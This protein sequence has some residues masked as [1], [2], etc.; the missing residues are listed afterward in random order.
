VDDRGLGKA[1]RDHGT[2]ISTSEA[3]AMPPSDHYLQAERLSSDAERMA[4]STPTTTSTP[5]G[6][7]T[8]TQRKP[9]KHG[10]GDRGHVLKGLRDVVIKGLRPPADEPAP[11]T[12]GTAG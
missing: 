3:T 9:R 6:A 1:D 2:S 4:D 5:T 7:T 12:P 8:S 10:S 11:A